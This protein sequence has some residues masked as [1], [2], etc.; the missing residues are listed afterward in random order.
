M[1]QSAINGL[2]FYLYGF[3]VNKTLFFFSGM[4]M[5][6]FKDAA[7]AENI[8]AFK[9]FAGLEVPVKDEDCG[10]HRQQREGQ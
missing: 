4:Q 5:D 3:Q 10:V 1:Q 9:S 7:L 8:V 2:E 6:L